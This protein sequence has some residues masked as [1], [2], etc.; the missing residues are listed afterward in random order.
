MNVFHKVTLASL[1][2][3]PVRT[4]VT[5][6]G[7]MLSAAMICAVTT[8][9]SSLRNFA[10]ENTVYR[11]GSWHGAALTADGNLLE[12]VQN[13]DRV[14]R[15]VYGQ[16]LG[17]AE[18]EGCKNEYKPYLYV[19]GVSEG[20]EEVL[21]I[22]L[23]A[24]EMP[25]ASNEILLPMHL[26][27]NGGVSYKIGD[28]ITLAL[29]YRIDGGYRLYQNNPL[30]YLTVPGEEAGETDVKRTEA[31]E[32][33]EER[34][35]LV[36]GFYE[37]PQFEEYTAP[38]YTALTA[39]DKTAGDGMEYDIYFEMKDPGDVYSFMAEADISGIRN[40]DVLT[41][42]GAFR[43]ASFYQVLWSLA[44]IIIGLILFGSVAL[45][46]NAFSISVSERTKQ[47]G[48][49]S[50]LGAT[51]KQLRK[52]V[53]F[54][55]L[56]VSAV[57]I[58]LGI[59]A[60]IGGIG[61]TLMVIGNRFT[62]LYGS[63]IPMRLSVSPTA[64]IVAI[65]VAL[66]TV[67]I[68]A[69]IPSKRAMKVSAVEA[70]RQ[71]KEIKARKR[72]VKTP[73][74]VYKIFGLPGMLANK[75]Y[76]RNRRKYRATVV[77]LF[78][79]IV[80]FVSASAFTQYLTDAATGGLETRNFDISFTLTEEGL[81]GND[82]QE[83][84]K[85]VQTCEGVSAGMY[86]VFS[87]T[88]GTAEIEAYSDWFRGMIGDATEWEEDLYECY[89]PDQEFRRILKENGLKEGDY[90]DR[91]APLALFWDGMQVFNKDSERFEKIYYLSDGNLN[92]T[93]KAV[94]RME[95]Y[96]YDG[97]EY[98]ENDEIVY[99]YVGKDNT[100]LRLKED[101]ALETI[102]LRG[103]ARLTGERPYYLPSEAF[104]AVYPLSMRDAVHVESEVSRNYR[105]YL[106]AKDHAVAFENVKKA[107]VAKGM[108]TNTAHDYA[109]AEE[110]D[111]NIITIVTVFSYGFIVLISLI[112]AANVFNT[113]STNIAL[114][115]REFAMLKSVG[116][117][118]GGLNRMMNFECIL[119]G[120]K[121]LLLGLPVSVGIT[122][123]IYLSVN[124]GFET[125]FRLPWD[126]IGIA[127]ASVFAVVFAT[128]MY[129][130]SKIKKDNPIDALKN[131]N[132]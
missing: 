116:M 51:K 105:F 109:E 13:S 75:Y 114:R 6:I 122:F 64:V 9:V 27:E 40:T 95:G 126:A 2:K 100:E 130:M 102:V 53:F 52:M 129:A 17:Y 131:E 93:V 8:S 119:Y 90:F 110:E 67:L 124:Q 30:S 69:W 88:R 76:K 57:G 108:T 71:N 45:I 73:K 20:F 21:P 34:T 35:Y 62:I 97:Y 83:V 91:S 99:R 59:L 66:I 98:D 103:G 121:A 80:L 3:N 42:M 32:I 41:L 29:G 26:A 10:L 82:P 7:I 115:R 43:Y 63:D 74:I 127:V 24:G 123:L 85:D 22:H 112:A 33:R 125:A 96:E 49:L 101:E 28:V 48:L 87:R 81:Y 4:T 60:G 31:L 23:T 120:T 15:T 92:F 78:M 86:S 11:E 25:D 47:F 79:S 72:D 36:V 46:Y 89:L 128:M 38:G 106:Q 117:T 58:P 94:R 19:L 111:R 56:A 107:L 65:L 77:S 5:I 39:A 132:L 118:A 44:V 1:K 113:I 12:R 18:A 37:R 14:K 50:S 104:L 16:Q 68:S 54:E 55:A 84:L 61:V 70:I